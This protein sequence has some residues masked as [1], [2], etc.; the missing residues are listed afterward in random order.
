MWYAPACETSP[1][2]RRGHASH[3]MSVRFSADDRYVI[4]AGGHD[5]GIFQWRT[6]GVAEPD[7]AQDQVILSRQPF[8]VDRH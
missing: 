4:S 5:R 2:A 3:V 7:Q 8:S 6:C 1:D